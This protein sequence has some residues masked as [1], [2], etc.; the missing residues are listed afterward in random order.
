MISVSFDYGHLGFSRRRASTNIVGYF[1]SEHTRFQAFPD[2]PGFRPYLWDH[3]QTNPA[4]GVKED[5]FEAGMPLWFFLLIFTFAP[6]LW[7]ANWRR[8]HHITVAVKRRICA[9]CGYDLRAT[10]DR[11]P[12]CGKIVERVI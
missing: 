8:D 1:N 7:I 9:A 11:C 10:P 4:V 2:P 3:W 12:E 6:I 5:H